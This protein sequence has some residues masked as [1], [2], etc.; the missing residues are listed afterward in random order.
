MD[1][2]RKRIQRMRTEGA[3]SDDES[4]ELLQALEGPR[5]E[6]SA[7]GNSSQTGAGVEDFMSCPKCRARVSA[8]APCCPS[9]GHPIRSDLAEPAFRAFRKRILISGLAMCIIGLPIGIILDLPYVW[10]LALVGIIVCT[11][12]LRLLV[13]RQQAP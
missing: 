9:C 2:E 13:R 10:V 1:E 5:D 3:I 12:K 11:I 8:Q 7:A 4:H 6:G